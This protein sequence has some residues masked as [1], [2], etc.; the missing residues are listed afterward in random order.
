MSLY[1]KDDF[2]ELYHGDCLTEHCIACGF[3][4]MFIDPDGLCINCYKES[5][6]GTQPE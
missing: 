6:H 4:S 1:Y 5:Q 3:A 2:V